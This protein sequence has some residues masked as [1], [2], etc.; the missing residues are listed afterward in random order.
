MEYLLQVN[1]KAP[2]PT[3]ENKLKKQCVMKVKGF[4]QISL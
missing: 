3:P 2:A 4:Y 1:P